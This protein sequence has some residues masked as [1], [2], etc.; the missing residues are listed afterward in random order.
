MIL[1][2]MRRMWRARRILSRMN[3]RLWKTGSLVAALTAAITLFAWPASLPSVPAH[4][5][6]PLPAATT[7]LTVCWIDTGGLDAPARYGVAGLAKTDAWHVTSAAILVRH[8]KGDVLIDAGLSPR[9]QEEANELGV[10]KRFVFSQ[11]AGR[12]HL[13]R[14][15][16]ES[17]RALGV[18]K[19]T[20]VI[21]SHAHADHLGGLTALPADVPLWLSAQEKAF[22]ESGNTVVMPAHARAAQ[23]RMTALEFQKT[24]FA[25]SD[26][27]ADLFGDGAIVVTPAFGHTPGSINTFVNAPGGRF[28]HV[29]D[30]INLRESLEREVPKSFPMRTLT[31]EDVSATST[32]VARLIELQKADPKLTILPA[33]DKPA[34]EALFGK[35][36]ALT[37][38]CVWW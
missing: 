22:I 12:N 36:D 16:T 5:F 15:L 3:A 37:P 38:P 1:S 13:R 29:G 32:Q 19:L 6:T 17:L 24:A 27:R 25:N 33:H 14:S 2:L 34:F 7:P 18:T 28:V 20:A 10:W 21:L 30:L 31:D 23:G 4:S 26:S 11:T 9:A 8:P 35:D